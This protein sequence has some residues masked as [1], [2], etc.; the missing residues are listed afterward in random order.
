MYVHCFCLDVLAPNL[1]FNYSKGMFPPLAP[2]VPHPPWK[3]LQTTLSS[4]LKVPLPPFSSLT[5]ASSP[6]EGIFPYF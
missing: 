1:L 2:L 4:V 6:S 3:E 5:V